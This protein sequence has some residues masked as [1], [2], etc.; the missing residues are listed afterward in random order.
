MEAKRFDINFE[1]LRIII[2]TFGLSI[3]THNLRQQCILDPPCYFFFFPLPPFFPRWLV[4]SSVC[5]SRVSSLTGGLL[6][7]PFGVRISNWMSD[8]SPAPTRPFLPMRRMKTSCSGSH[9]SA[10]FVASLSGATVTHGCW[11]FPSAQASRR[12]ET[13]FIFIIRKSHF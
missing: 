7:G 10:G 8:F 11:G 12:P 2:Y 13:W 4:T 6:S 1:L 5:I 9:I 3:L